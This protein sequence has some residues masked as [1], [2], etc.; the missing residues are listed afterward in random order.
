MACP[1]PGPHSGL[2]PRP[3]G[4]V[5]QGDSKGLRQEVWLTLCVKNLDFPLGVSGRADRFLL[6]LELL[7][8]GAGLGVRGGR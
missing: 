4:P 3:V 8:R 6:A 2:H 1:G 7:W 5:P